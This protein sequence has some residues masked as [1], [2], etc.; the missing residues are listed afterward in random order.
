MRSLFLLIIGLLW[1][2]GIRP[3]LA[4]SDNTDANIPSAR[5]DSTRQYR[6]SLQYVFGGQFADFQAINTILN[7]NGYKSASNY[8]GLLGGTFLLTRP[9]SQKWP[10]QFDFTALGG[11]R[12][13]TTSSDNGT[14]TSVSQTL[15]MLG[16]G[17]GLVSKNS[18]Q[19]GPHIGIGLQTT[20][21][22]A[23]QN[24]G[25]GSVTN[26]IANGPVVGR[27]AALTQTAGVIDL[28]WRLILMR[29]APTRRFVFGRTATLSVGY[30]LGFS[31]RNWYLDG[32]SGYSFSDG[33]ALNA[34]GWYFTT[35]Y[36]L[37]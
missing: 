32:N 15:V 7:D 5:P 35:S 25:I 22:R 29:N 33:P 19:T 17:I 14:N 24:L 28:G 20:T 27:Y 11:I 2:G 8:L 18:L 10:F 6:L 13:N 23:T 31:R 3:A 36:S 1:F 30:R 34:G 4:Q 12:R 37:W 16:A 21:F 26:Y 9:Y